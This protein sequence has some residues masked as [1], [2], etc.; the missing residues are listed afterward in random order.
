[1][2]LSQSYA[3]TPEVQ[4]SPK[5]L[6]F[7]GM[8]GL[9]H[10]GLFFATLFLGLQIP[11]IQAPPVVEVEFLGGKELTT[12]EP[13]SRLS[14]P[15]RLAAETQSP[16]MPSPQLKRESVVIPKQASV[17][18]VTKKIPK[19]AGATTAPKA[20]KSAPAAKIL[21]SEFSEVETPAL[22]TDDFEELL[23]RPTSF[24]SS[25]FNAESLDSDLDAIDREAETK[26]KKAQEKF[27][28]E[29]RAA[30]AQ[31]EE[32][33]AAAAEQ[34]RAQEEA[35]RKAQAAAAAAA[36]ALEAQKIA[37]AQKGNSAGMG[38]P[39]GGE[40]RSLAELRQVQG[41]AR[42]QYEVEDRLAGRQGR[43]IFHA[44]VN[45]NGSLSGFRM[46]QS[47]G[48]RSL[49]AKTLKALKTWRFQ[50]GQQ[51][52]VELPFQWDLVGGAKEVKGQL[53]SR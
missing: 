2:G 22:A 44:Y 29:A 40:I 47:T 19:T 34:L 38:Y 30:Q 41:N 20:R 13:I 11:Q 14:P 39:E 35:E 25:E 15:P 28:K 45:P 36:A 1:M 49:D 7:V 4:E 26:L 43:V 5:T 32:A 9:L 51:G 33:Q 42:P 10:A 12:P 3:L 8:S 31:F 37:A 50:E 17:E 48:H 21:K 16:P 18:P 6:G 46:I 27:A 52:W 24:A 23:N 53:R